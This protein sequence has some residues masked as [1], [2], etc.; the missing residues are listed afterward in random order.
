MLEIGGVQPYQI[1]GSVITA[2]KQ[3][4]VHIADGKG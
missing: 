1:S 2:E 4:G 3:V